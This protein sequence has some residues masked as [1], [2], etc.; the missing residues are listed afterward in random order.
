MEGEYRFGGRKQDKLRVKDQLKSE[1]Q[2]IEANKYASCSVYSFL[3]L[4]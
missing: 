1:R 2:E 4:S 3:R